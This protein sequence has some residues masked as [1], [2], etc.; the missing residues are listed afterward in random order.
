[1]AAQLQAINKKEAHL[2]FAGRGSRA[3]VVPL[4]QEEQREGYVAV[5]TPRNRRVFEFLPREASADPPDP[6][7]VMAAGRAAGPRAENERS[8][9][10]AMSD[11]L[12]A[13]PTFERTV[14]LL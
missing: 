14:I 13:K 3:V 8:V 9:P 12:C 2:R 10:R 11:P 7:E 4:P 5:R 6:A 1:M